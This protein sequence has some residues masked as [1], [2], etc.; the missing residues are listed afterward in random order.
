MPVLHTCREAALLVSRLLDP[1]I[2]FVVVV[3]LFFIPCPPGGYN[4]FTVRELM[5]MAR[6]PIVWPLSNGPAADDKLR[7]RG[8]LFEVRKLYSAAAWTQTDAVI[9]FK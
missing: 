6:P 1:V 2:L 8:A 7:T 9:V 4:L 3:I 5:E